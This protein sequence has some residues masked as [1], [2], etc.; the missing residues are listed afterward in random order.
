M[1]IIYLLIILILCIC[2]KKKHII[3]YYVCKQPIFQPQKWN[4]KI[5]NIQEYNNCYA[6]A[7]RDHELNRSE[8]P[9]PGDKSNIKRISKDKYTCENFKTNI[10]S[11][12]PNILDYNK[13]EE[14]CLCD[15]YKIALFLDDSKP[16]KDYHFYRQ[17][18]N[19]SWSHKP[20]NGRA[21]NY[22]ASGNII[23]NPFNSDRYF[24]NSKNKNNYNTFCGYFCVPYKH[25][26]ILDNKLFK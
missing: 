17:D 6:Y 14:D 21:R 9:Q 16:H 10:M 11:D 15:Y 12:Y 23:Y 8:K 2:L 4:K 22:D 3:E 25:N 13:N 5:D 1:K 20:G 7:M 24:K 18:K 19:L 26:N